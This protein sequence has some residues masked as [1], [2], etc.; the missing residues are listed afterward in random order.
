VTTKTTGALAPTLIVEGDM[1]YSL[2]GQTDDRCYAVRL[3]GEGDVTESH[4]VWRSRHGAYVSSPLFHEGL[5]F[6]ADERGFAYCAD[7]ET[8]ALLYRERI[9]AEFYA[10]PVQADDVLYYVSRNSG[11]FVLPAGAEFEVLAHNRI[12]TDAGRFD[13]SPAISDGRMYLRS[14]THLYCVAKEGGEE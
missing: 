5:L 4:V 2:G 1:L 7:A 14:G 3:G 6:W 11:T 12:E 10:S 13:A 9:D 8:G